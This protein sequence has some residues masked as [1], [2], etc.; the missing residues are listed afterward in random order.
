MGSIQLWLVINLF[1]LSPMLDLLGILELC[2]FE[3]SEAISNLVWAIIY[4]VV[5][6]FDLTTHPGVNRFDC[7]YSTTPPHSRKG[8]LFKKKK[9]EGTCGSLINEVIDCWSFIN[10][11]ECSCVNMLSKLSEDHPWIVNLNL[12]SQNY[13]HVLLLNIYIYLNFCSQNNNL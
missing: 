13:L 1:I 3:P 11:R 7:T 2:V 10:N 5:K 6:K 12:F 8:G 4:F 9:K